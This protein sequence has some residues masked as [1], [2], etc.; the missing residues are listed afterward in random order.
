ML[1]GFFILDGPE[2]LLTHRGRTD[3]TKCAHRYIVYL[4]AP[5]TH[6]PYCPTIS[7]AP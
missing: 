2:F 5:E 1:R 7:E 6:S 4:M 3:T